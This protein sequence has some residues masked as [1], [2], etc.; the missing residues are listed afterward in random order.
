MAAIVAGVTK[1]VE[2][3]EAVAPVVAGKFPRNA[4]RDWA[5]SGNRG[6]S[7]RERSSQIRV[8]AVVPDAILI[9]L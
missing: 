4:E 3:V 8:P 6:R 5:T 7:S 9:P 1:E 2:V